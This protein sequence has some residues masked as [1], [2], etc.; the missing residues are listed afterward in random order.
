MDCI[1][2]TWRGGGIGKPDRGHRGKSQLERGGVDLKFNTYGGALLFSLFF[3]NWKSGRRAIRVRTFILAYTKITCHATMRQAI[4]A[5]APSLVRF[6][7][8]SQSGK[9]DC[10]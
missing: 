1:I 5:L 7:R 9:R 10:S 4:F 6:A 3:T 8:L 2:I